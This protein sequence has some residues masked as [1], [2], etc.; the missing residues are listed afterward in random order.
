[1]SLLQWRQ[2]R[3]RC[4][5]SILYIF[6]ID[7]ITRRWIHYI[8][9]YESNSMKNWRIDVNVSSLLNQRK[10]SSS[11]SFVVIVNDFL[12]QYL[13]S[14]KTRR[15][16]K[17]RKVQIQEVWS[18]IRSRNRY[19]FAVFISVIVLFKKSIVSSY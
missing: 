18:N 8:Q 19:R 1:M 5:H 16:I 2:K 7:N 9:R 11:Q 3:M 13:Q 12:S 17:I 6:A 4:F 15:L 10:S 14:I